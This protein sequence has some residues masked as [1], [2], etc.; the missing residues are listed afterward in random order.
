MLV[1]SS[2]PGRAASCIQE[3]IAATG[4]NLLLCAGR[5]GSRESQPTIWLVLPQTF[6]ISAVFVQIPNAH[7]RALQ[8]VGLSCLLEPRCANVMPVRVTAPSWIVGGVTISRLGYIPRTVNHRRLA[9]LAL[10]LSIALAGCGSSG[11]K[12]S[13]GAKSGSSGKNSGSA[14]KQTVDASRLEDA[15]AAASHTQRGQKAA[16]VCPTG[17]PVKTG[18][19][20]YCAA[21]AGTQ[22]TP[23][24]VTEHSGGRLTYVGVSATRAPMLDMGQIELSVMRSLRA[25]HDDPKSLSCPQ[26][27][28]RQQGLEFVCV[29]TSSS[30]RSTA[31]IVRETN[32]L[33]RVSFRPR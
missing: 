16:V 18:L 10:V 13:G 12:N 31:F 29:A 4:A 22:V 9:F 20:F 14:S 30:K 8:F 32:G 11:A 6:E 23:F 28:P 7:T 2:A 26:Q 15:I 27:M 25:D 5:W 24:L 17:I 3:Q 33:G 1:G 21:Q 19:D